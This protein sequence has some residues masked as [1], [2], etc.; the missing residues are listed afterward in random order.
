[1]D[2]GLCVLPVRDPPGLLSILVLPYRESAEA[3][4]RLFSLHVGRMHG[5]E[6]LCHSAVRPTSGG[7]PPPPAAGALP[8]PP[9]RPAVPAALSNCPCGDSIRRTSPSDRSKAPAS[10]SQLRQ[11]AS[12]ARPTTPMA[13]TPCLSIGSLART[14][15]L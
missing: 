2:A 9:R 1:M 11:A 8:A 12:T 6:S 14:S 15:V 4:A 7:G 10:N 13:G 5:S 3:A